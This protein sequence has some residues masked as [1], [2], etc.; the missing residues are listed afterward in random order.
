M[1]SLLFVPYYLVSITVY[2]SIFGKEHDPAHLTFVQ[3]VSTA[4]L[5]VLA[6]PFLETAYMNINGNFLILIAYLAVM[7][8]V[9]ALYVMAKYQRN[10]TPTRSAVIYSMEP[11]L[12]ALFAFLIIGEQIG[13]VGIVG[14]VL[15]LL[16]LIISELSD[17][18]FKRN[19]GND[20]NI[21]LPWYSDFVFVQE[22]YKLFFFQR[23][24]WFNQYLR[25]SK[26]KS[27]LNAD[28]I[29]AKKYFH[30]SFSVCNRI[31]SCFSSD[32]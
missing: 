31:W 26:P 2:L 32:Y 24:K 12:A 3:F 11:P 6:I 22:L 20:A 19:R 8:T 1:H 21:A 27:I 28:E 23:K 9:V 30:N 5:S 18:I 17:V 15:I 7:P 29:G 4:L 10:T 14:G 25:N 16:G 13:M